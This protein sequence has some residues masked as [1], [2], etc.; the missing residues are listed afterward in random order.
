MKRSE[1]SINRNS[2][3]KKY[4]LALDQGTSS[5][6]AIL[7][8][9]EL[10]VIDIEQEEVAS[11]FP[12]E[13]W[14]EQDAAEIWISQQNVMQKLLNRTGIKAGEIAGIGITNQRETT[15]VWD[16]SGKPVYNAI[17]WQDSRTARMCDQIKSS[18]LADYIKPATGLV[19]NPYFSATK[20]AWIL[21]N[22]PRAR[23]RAEKGELYF[24]TIDSW[25]IWNLTKGDLHITDHSNASRTLLYNINE[26]RWDDNIL[27]YFDIPHVMLPEVRSSSG[28]FGEIAADILGKKV[29]IC[30]IAGDQQAALFG[31]KC[32]L[33]GMAKNTYGTGCFL[34]M[35]TGKHKVESKTNLL[36]TIA[37]EI[38]GEVTYALEGSVFMGGAVVKWLRDELHLVQSAAE[39]EMIA[40]SIND[41]GGVY[42]V[43]AFTGL[44]APYWDTQARGIICGLTG[45]SGKA[46]IV[47]AA[48]EAMAYQTRDILVSMER[49]ANLALKELHVDG[50]ASANNFLMQFQSDILGCQVQRP[51]QVEVTA[52][53]AAMLAAKA[54]NLGEITGGRDKPIAFEPIISVNNRIRFCEGWENA[55][56]KARSNSADQSSS[57]SK[58]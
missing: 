4:V 8:N 31:H 56:K 6:R 41:N 23:S 25:L 18:I 20:L 14:V 24:G 47:R 26:L 19:I 3:M 35:N 11:I 43:P 30:G 2:P 34:L 1:N 39:T 58:G 27:N 51:Q 49:D 32:L 29:K 38:D 7:F 12:Y 21:D 13:G 15:V 5:S 42:F 44:G 40:Q 57:I 52:L 37:W 9:T 54:L 48:L 16:K 10:K 17:S 50:G 53:G 46:H 33:P 55:V 28:I 22:V 36:T 45:V